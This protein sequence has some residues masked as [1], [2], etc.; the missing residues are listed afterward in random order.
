MSLPDRKT[1]ILKFAYTRGLS[2]P[3]WAAWQIGSV[4]GIR[5]KD[6][7]PEDWDVGFA[8]TLAVL[9]VLLPMIMSRAALIGV[10]VAGLG[11][12]TFHWPYKLGMLLVVV[13]GML[14]AIACQ[15]WQDHRARLNTSKVNP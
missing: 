7:I 12:M 9:C 15:E 6:T 1:G 5:R 8:G 4:I 13:A 11:V 2:V 3:N 10:V 14:S